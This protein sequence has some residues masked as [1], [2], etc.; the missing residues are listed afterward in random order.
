MPRPLSITLTVT[1]ARCN[2][3]A[4]NKPAMPAPTT[5]TFEGGTG[6]DEELLVGDDRLN[7]T[8]PVWTGE[9]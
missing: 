4:A 1:P 5:S 7:D 6:P 3:T 8:I 2:S 9:V